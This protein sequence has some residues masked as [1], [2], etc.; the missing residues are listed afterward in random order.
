[1]IYRFFSSV[2]HNRYMESGR[3]YYYLIKPIFTAYEQVLKKKL[4]PSKFGWVSFSGSEDMKVSFIPVIPYTKLQ[5][6]ILI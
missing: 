6:C 3:G 1:M 5:F 2:R 4:P